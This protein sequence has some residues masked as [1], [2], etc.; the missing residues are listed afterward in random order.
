[1]NAE[2]T[3]TKRDTGWNCNHNI[4]VLPRESEAKCRENKEKLAIENPLV[5]REYQPLG[6]ANGLLS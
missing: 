1:M 2:E 5:S 3:T 4:Y 6:T